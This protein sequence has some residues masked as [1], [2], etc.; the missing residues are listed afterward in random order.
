[1]PWNEASAMS[2]RIEF[3]ALATAEGANVRALCRR[4]GIS[5][6]T[7]YKWIARARAGGPDALADRSRRPATSPR[8]RPDELEAAVLQLRDAHPAWG[9][10]KL[11]ACLRRDGRA[12]APAAS[13]ITAILGR[14]G[15]LDPARAAAHRPAVRFEHDAPNRLWQMDFKGHFA[16]A[17]GARCH[18]LTVLD[19]HSRFALG[20]FACAD[21]RDATVRGHLEALFGRYGLPERILC[22]NGP[23]WGTAGSG[24][25]YSAPRVWLLRRG[26][27][28]GHGRPAHP[29]TQGK[30][31]RFHRTLDAEVLQGRL[32]ADLAACTRAFDAWREVYNHR[33]PHEALG[34]AVPAS[35]YAASPRPYVASPPAWEYGPTDAVRTVSCD[36]TVS[37]R[38][39]PHAVGKA[40]RGERVAVRPTPAE[41]RYEV[42]FG[43]HR[44]AELDLGVQNRPGD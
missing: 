8:R 26:V 6:R 36:G 12:D 41:G 15:R 5:P 42:Y 32:L 21:E 22:D 4:Y 39:R 27:A 13:T 19:D 1:M 31:E 44:I 17:A 43:V 40:F 25:P 29:Q 30:D 23:P 20:L 7:A 9:G 10:R 18:P 16:T 35:R 38:G 14:H 2:L 28:V 24:Q 3:V 33:R 11:R 37:F 34:M